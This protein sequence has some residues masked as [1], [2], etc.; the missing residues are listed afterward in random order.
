MTRVVEEWIKRGSLKPDQIA[1]LC[2]NRQEHS[3]LAGV[4]KLAKTPLTGNLERWTNG[5]GVLFSTIRSFKGL[6]ADAVVMLDVPE[7]DAVPFF[8]TADFYVGA[9]R[10]KHLLAIIATTENLM[11]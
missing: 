1:I 10:A 8:S 9:S 2:P 4:T 11:S 6:E 5:Q 3:S 7:P